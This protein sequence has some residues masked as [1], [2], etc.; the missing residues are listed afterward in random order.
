MPSDQAVR[1]S[2]TALRTEIKGDVNA[3][4][5]CGFVERVFGGAICAEI[6]QLPCH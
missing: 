6:L 1:Q 2:S 5:R 3:T 4:L